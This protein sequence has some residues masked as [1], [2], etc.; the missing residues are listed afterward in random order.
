MDILLVDDD[1]LINK[2]MRW[3]LLEGEHQVDCAFN[4]VEAFDKA[5][6]KQYDVILMDMHMPVMDGHNATR[7]LRDNNYNGLIIAVTASVMAQETESAINS[8]CDYFIPKPIGE[9]FESLVERY[10][11]KFNNNG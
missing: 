3:R 9:D 2:M 11:E 1:E 6:Q 7:K 4:G 8:G 5:S 10:I